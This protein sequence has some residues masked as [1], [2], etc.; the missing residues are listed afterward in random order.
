[1]A[2]AL[3]GMSIH[4]HGASRATQHARGAVSRSQRLVGLMQTRRL[5]A[6]HAQLTVLCEAL[7]E[8]IAAELLS[9][10]SVATARELLDKID[11]KLPSATDHHPAG[12]AA[13]RLMAGDEILRLLLAHE[14]RYSY[15][16]PTNEQ[17]AAR[18]DWKPA[19]VSVRQLLEELRRGGWLA[20]RGKGAERRYELT[21]KGR[22]RARALA[23]AGQADD[24]RPGRPSPSSC[25]T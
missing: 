6:T 3:G 8:S 21:R 18:L 5:T 14:D 1:M 15:S 2:A 13:G 24:P 19:G 10:T 20:G 11:A 23:D 22:G 17:I 25:S 12:P 16:A 7:R 4:G 9:P